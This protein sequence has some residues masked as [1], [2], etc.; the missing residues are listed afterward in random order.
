MEINE[1]NFKTLAQYLQQTLSPDQN[2]RRPGTISIHFSL[3]AILPWFQSFLTFPMFFFYFVYYCRRLRRRE[4]AEQFLESV[5][6]NQN[7]AILLLNLVGKEDVDMT[8]RVAGSIAFKNFVK[9]NWNAHAVS[10]AIFC[11]FESFFRGDFFSVATGFCCC[12]CNHNNE[13][14]ERKKLMLIFCLEGKKYSIRVSNPWN[15]VKIDLQNAFFF[16]EKWK[17]TEFW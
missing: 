7:Y 11:N 17:I 5:E 15:S 10:C 6:S 9:R 16:A 13:E 2:V 8:I 14:T 4:I 3:F 12:C 1:E